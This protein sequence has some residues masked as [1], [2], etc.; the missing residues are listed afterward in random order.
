MGYFCGKQDMQTLSAAQ[1][2]SFLLSNGLGGYASVTA[3]YSV[4]RCDQGILVAAV[5]APNERITMVHR[6]QEELTL[7]DKKTVLSTQAFADRKKAEEGYRHLAGFWWEDAPEWWYQVGA[8][9]VRRQLYVARGI[10]T[11]AVIYEIE[12]H[13]EESC[14][15]RVEPFLKF[16][17]KE[18]ALE[19]KKEFTFDSGKVTDG[20]YTMYLATNGKTRKIRTRW[21]S[22]SYP[23]DAKDGRPAKGLTGSCFRIALSV[24]AGKTEKLEIVFSMDKEIPSA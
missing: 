17:P 11:A 19:E 4:P 1:R 5:K 14:T 16:A 13:A 22:L 15:L 24:A 23:E 9:A 18:Q 6:L 20:T 10:N 3:A 12:N 7:G 8:V 21:Q 2:S